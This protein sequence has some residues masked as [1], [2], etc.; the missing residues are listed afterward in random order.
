VL[1]LVITWEDGLIVDRVV[2]CQQAGLVDMTQAKAARARAHRRGFR[3]RLLV[4]GSG[5]QGVG[6]SCL[7]SP[8]IYYRLEEKEMAKGPLRRSKEA[9]GRLPVAL[10]SFGH[11]QTDTYTM[12]EM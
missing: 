7:S 9:T 1:R 8:V 6:K 5:R 4:L 10:I 11:Y 3:L 2:E 12:G